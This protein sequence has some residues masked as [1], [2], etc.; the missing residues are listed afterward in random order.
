MEN[1]PPTFVE[2]F[3]Q[4][5]QLYYEAL[6]LEPSARAA[7]LAQAC[8]NNEALRREVESLLAA[9]DAAGNFIAGNAVA[10]QLISAPIL[11][12]PPDAA[13]PNATPRA[14]N[15]YRF[16]SLLGQGGMGEVWLADDT[17]LHRKVALKLLPAQFATDAARVRRFE[18]EAHAISALNHPNII[19]LFDLGHAGDDYFMATEFVDGQ[20]L[21][22]RLRTNACLPL[23]EAANLAAQVCQALAAAHEAG[24]IHRDIKP[25]NLMIRPDG[26]VKV[27]DFGLA[28][29]NESLTAPAQS[30]LTDSGM[31]MGTASYMS[32]EQARGEKIDARTDIFSLGIVL[33]EM[34]EGRTPFPGATVF[35][36]IGAI[37]NRE[38]E[39]MTIAS[40][41]WQAV[42]Q[43]AL[44]KDRTERYQTI[45]EMWEMLAELKQLK[46][47]AEIRASG[48][49]EAASAASSVATT[50][51]NAFARNTANTSSVFKRSKRTLAA[52]VTALGLVLMGGGYAGYRMMQRNTTPAFT[53]LMTAKAI[54]LTT[55]P[56]METVPAFSPDG[57]LLAFAWGGEKNEN[58]DIFIKQIDGEGMFRLTNHPASESDPAW[59]PDG[60]QLAFTRFTK[61]DCG[62]YL[63]PA[64]GGVER[65]LTTLSPQRPTG[66]A[67]SELNWSPDGK[68]LA[69]GDRESAQAPLKINLL[70]LETG[71]RQPLTNPPPGSSGDFLPAFSPDGKTL[72]FVRTATADSHREIL[73]V[74]VTGGES[75]QITKNTQQ[76][77]SLA[78]LGNNRE[79]VFSGLVEGEKTSIGLHQ[80]NINTGQQQRLTGPDALV[81]GAAYDPHSGRLCYAKLDYDVDVWRMGL[82][83]TVSDQ[84]PATKLIG[85][86]KVEFYQRYSPDGKKLA[87]QTALSGND[88]V[89]ICD[90]DGQNHRQLTNDP[91]ISKGW[92]DWSPDSK[93]ISYVG[94]SNGEFAIYVAELE[95]GKHRRVT[96]D[97]FN[98]STPSWSRD[99]Q[100]IYFSSDRSGAPQIYQI[101]A[102]GGE[103]V[104][105]TRQG[106]IEPLESLDGKFLVY[107]KNRQTPGLWR[108]DLATGAETMIT[109]VHKAGYLRMWDVTRTGIFFGSNE[110][111][112]RALIEFYEF[113]TG[114]ISLVTKL[115]HGFSP[116]TRGLA[117]SPDG[118]WLTYLKSQLKS[119]LMLTEATE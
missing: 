94:W 71:Q 97:D 55:F 60:K 26:Y 46:Q 1:A 115:N 66:I 74:P 64:I 10:D 80:I 33:Y 62:I 82:K 79:L 54:S 44:R 45:H 36:V 73:L 112:T 89:W 12:S 49:R 91:K 58:L 92:P 17:R 19:T 18:Q 24:I 20:T 69:F 51:E 105:V 57:K 25:E 83:G 7:F 116:G 65:K 21:R 95:T 99:G 32:P 96:R 8:T 108:F 78:W 4:A 113:A 59:S 85:S 35:E 100:L 103:P 40:A 41:E 48:Q 106:G 63:M 107:V 22:D 88:A 30:S 9:H 110:S 101:A 38:P 72:A 15:Q 67:G 2:L 28:H 39:V 23:D 53:P 109:D 3:Q 37:L 47:Q 111:A 43:K 52:S 104:Q 31:V 5:E 13:L 70:N 56:G 6:E 11:A 16:V 42:V 29:V 61:P 87:Y 14:I 114:K 27:L 118:R 93:Q 77:N 86:T 119:D 98:N 117:V 84:Q 90:S 76:I 34:I 50:H 75:R 102:A 68:L 81:M